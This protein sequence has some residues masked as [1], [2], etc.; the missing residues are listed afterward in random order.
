VATNVASPPGLTSESGITLTPPALSD[1]MNYLTTSP[2]SHA[3]NFTEFRD[4]LLLLPRKVSAAEIY[5]YYE[6]KKYL[7]DDGRGVARVTMEGELV[8]RS[9]PFSS[10]EASMKPGDVSLSAE[11]KPPDT[12][13][14]SN[15]EQ[16]VA[17]T[18]SIAHEHDLLAD[19]DEEEHHGFLESHTALKFLLAGGIAGAGR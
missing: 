8:L 3:I 5:Q 2:H 1:F 18:E 6:M 15:T 14:N 9:R 4:F 19:D 12:H 7:G 13:R 10:H 11:D 16:H 17:E